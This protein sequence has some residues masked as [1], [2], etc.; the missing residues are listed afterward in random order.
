MEE[1]V[2]IFAGFVVLCLLIW[3][4]A[5][6]SLQF[7]QVAKAKGYYESKYFWM[8]FWLGAIGYLLVIALV[9]KN[10]IADKTSSDELPEI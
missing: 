9:P 4:N 8:C 10:T 2:L 3:L 7:E 5:F 1:E 6:I